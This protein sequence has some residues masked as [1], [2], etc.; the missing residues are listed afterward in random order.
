MIGATL[1]ATRVSI[2]VLL[3][4]DRKI[5]FLSGIGENGGSGES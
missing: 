5:G 2:L 4:S 3:D 1:R